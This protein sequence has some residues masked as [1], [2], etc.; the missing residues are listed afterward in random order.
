MRI[1]VIGLLIFAASFR[2]DED[3]E[4]P[5]PKEQYDALVKKYADDLQTAIRAVREAKTPA[6][7][8]AIHTPLPALYAPGFLKLAE[9]YE[10]TPTAEDALVWIGEHCPTCPASEKAREILAR[11][12]IRSDKLKPVLRHLFV[13]DS[14]ASEVLLRKAMAESPHRDVRGMACYWLAGYVWT[15]SV[16]IRAGD[17][18]RDR[19]P[20]DVIQEATNL[21]EQVIA[22]YSDVEYIPHVL[23]RLPPTLGKAAQ[24]Q[25]FEIRNLAV[26]KVAPEIKG[27]D[28]DQ[29][30]F[31]L[32]AYRGKI[33]VLN[34]G[35]MTYCGNC[36][37]MIP[38]ERSLV[39]R[40]KDKPFALVGI[41]AD[42]SRE[43]LKSKLGASDVT[44]RVVWDGD[45][46]G[47]IFSAWNI[48]FMPEIFVIDPRGVI[49]YRVY[50]DGKVLN[51][52]VD[53]LLKEMDESSRGGTRAGVPR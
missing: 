7:K 11:D 44:W 16:W 23:G 12:F 15:K 38:F 53:T 42:P 49:R 18:P 3:S 40:L 43:K 1:L 50:V 47:P 35:S 39:E 26:G 10:G 13:P 52:A 9:K 27:T 8:V 36:V 2:G 20:D 45:F 28:V 41:N 14:K 4:P 32:S 51:E 48:R 17:L 37:D 6:E 25:L 19:D 5:T 21:F 34:F 29:K 22:T 31:Q 46:G 33:V 24:Q 30:P